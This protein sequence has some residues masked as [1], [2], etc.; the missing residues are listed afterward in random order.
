MQ[1]RTTALVFLF[2]SEWTE[3]KIKTN[4]GKIVP[5]LLHGWNDFGK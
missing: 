4:D 2:V 1:F 3:K 5:K